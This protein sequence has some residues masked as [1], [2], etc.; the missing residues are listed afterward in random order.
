MNVETE[1]ISNQWKWKRWDVRSDGKVFWAYEKSCSSGEH[2]I[3]WE[4]AV[5]LNKASAENKTRRRSE[6]PLR[7]QEINRNWHKRKKEKTNQDRC[8][9]SISSEERKKI[10][11]RIYQKSRYDSDPLFATMGRLRAR[12]R[13]FLKNKNSTKTSTTK[14]IIGCSGEQLKVYIESKFQDGMSWENRSQWHID[15]IVPLASA[16][17]L[18]EVIK[19]C[20]YTNLQPLW[21]KDNLSKGCKIQQ[22]PKKQ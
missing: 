11:N 9:F 2:W 17:S 7:F 16:K 18:D 3:E 21:A 19:L 8:A 1:N 22:Q 5:S 12:V 4:K 6:N 20:H 13:A 10:Q 15:H 14:E